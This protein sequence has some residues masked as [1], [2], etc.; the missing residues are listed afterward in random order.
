MTTLLKQLDFTADAIAIKVN[1]S[2]AVFAE[3][4][5]LAVIEKVVF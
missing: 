1:N 3:E 2:K 5:R 4:I